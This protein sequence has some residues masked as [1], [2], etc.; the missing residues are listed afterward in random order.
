MDNMMEM[1]RLGKLTVTDSAMKLEDISE[2]FHKIKFV[3]Y[4]IVRYHAEHLCHLSA[5]EYIGYSPL[6]DELKEDE[7]IPEYNIM[8]TEHGQEVHVER[9]E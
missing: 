3:P 7:V 1:D 8:F 6:F 2:V 5:L 9:K 4:R